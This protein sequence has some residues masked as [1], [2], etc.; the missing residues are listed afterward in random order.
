LF[1]DFLMFSK[2]SIFDPALWDQK[3]EFFENVSK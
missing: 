3:I 1:L 2:K